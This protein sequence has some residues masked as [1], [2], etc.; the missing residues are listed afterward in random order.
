[1]AIAPPA[2]VAPVRTTPLKKTA[3]SWLRHPLFRFV[4]SIKLAVVL[5]SV[6]IIAAIAGTLYESHFDSD[7]AR[8]Y[9]YGAPWFNAWLF[10]LVVN[11][12]ASALSRMPWKPKHV[13]FLITH[14]GIVILLIGAVIGRT[15]G[16][17]GTMTLHKDPFPNNQLITAERQL[18]LLTPNPN[19]IGERI[20]RGF[21]M[22]HIGH[23]LPSKEKPWKIGQLTQNWVMELVGYSKN[24]LVE[25]K[26]TPSPN[27]PPAVHV[28]LTSPRL[29]QTMESWLLADS[30]E[31]HSL[32]LGIA[33]VELRSESLGET[34][35]DPPTKNTARLHCNALGE[36]QYAF[37]L[38][39]GSPPIAAGILE[40]GKAV[41]TGWADW[42]LK[43]DEVIAQAKE[44]L[45]IQENATPSLTGPNRA[46]TDGL[47]VRLRPTTGS[48][49]AITQWVATG[50]PVHVQFQQKDLELAYSWKVE[51]LP[52]GLQLKNFEV[53]HNEGT[54]DPAGFKSTVLVT[55]WDGHQMEGSC[56]MNHPM[57]Y[58]N[59]WFSIWTGLTYKI[60]QSNYTEGDLNQSGVQILRDPGWLFKWVGSVLICTGI[61]SLFYL[62]P[63][64]GPSK[65][66][67][68]TL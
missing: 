3:Y 61:F 55:D 7:V 42:E 43:V 1:M 30:S 66:K 48:E 6:M 31:N 5:L 20:V 21:P 39:N 33:S 36:V 56:W 28:C 65:A 25:F 54:S 26:P 9:V 59:R 46:V 53:E 23:R 57:N 32:D 51:P 63:Y 16:I 10:F 15:W 8:D 29:K 47:L 27:G 67:R 44:D 52:I 11:L 13:S 2:S 12:V 24:L 34:S 68:K 37:Y 38:G 18:Y 17:E 41:H 19:H 35:G 49:P 22:P 14:L 60:S 50:W 45:L 4:S 58:P 62:R 40:K 64:G